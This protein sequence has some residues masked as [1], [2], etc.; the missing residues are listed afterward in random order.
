MTLYSHYGRTHYK[1]CPTCGGRIIRI[2]K[3][4][5]RLYVSCYPDEYRPLGSKYNPVTG[6]RQYGVLEQCENKHW[7]NNC[8]EH[9]DESS[10]H[11]SDLSELK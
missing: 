4:A 3:S 8:Y 2:I 9:I 7:F 6:R 11:D 10:V 1:F 5:H